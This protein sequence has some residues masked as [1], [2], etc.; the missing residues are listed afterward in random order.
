V[1]SLCSIGELL[2]DFTPAG[3][4]AAGNALFERNPGGGPANMAV[5]AAKLGMKAEFVG[6]VGDDAFGRFLRETLER[7]GVGT[8]GLRVSERVRTTL[9]FV[10]LFE[11][12]DRDFSFYRD[13]GAD[14]SL[15][16]RDVDR[17]IVDGC[18]AFHFSSVSLTC[19]PSR[20]A[21]KWAARR[22][23]RRGKLVS[24]DPNLRPPLWKG[25]LAE[26]KRQIVSMIRCA[27][28][29]KIS[30][31]EAEF[32]HPGMRV[33]DAARALVDAGVPSVFVTL[34]PGG[35]HWANAKGAGTERTYDK[36]VVDTT[37]C[38][39]AFTAAVVYR[40]AESGKHP[41]SLDPAEMAD[42][43]DFANA[44][45]ACAATRRGGIPAMPVQEEIERCRREVPKLV[46]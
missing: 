41:G 17:S 23:R 43:A 26:A 1:R 14:M 38:G 36:K 37:G 5:G 18:D 8:K 27:D 45:G 21:V 35:C 4:S 16:R 19:E 31:E 29:L 39:D 44:A 25:D 32:L 28:I 7:A 34:G 46:P 2:I 33:E 6:M 11:N 30:G 15:A 22:A 20:G 42:I 12:G 24:F 40:I 13:P 3:D 10:H 9:A